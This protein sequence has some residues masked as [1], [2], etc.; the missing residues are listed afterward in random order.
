M[1]IFVFYGSEGESGEKTL[2][3]CQT[4][5]AAALG[6]QKPPRDAQVHLGPSQVMVTVPEGK[7]AGEDR[8]SVWGLLA[9]GLDGFARPS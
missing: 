7:D 8:V 9:F 2:L 1:A 3:I 4:L 5:S 6:T